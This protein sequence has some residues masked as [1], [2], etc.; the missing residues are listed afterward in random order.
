VVE[1]FA[2]TPVFAFYFLRARP[3]LA[4]AVIDVVPPRLKGGQT[5][6]M[7][8][9]TMCS[10]QGMIRGDDEHGPADPEQV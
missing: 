9:V 5:N 8:C 6:S 3:F 10:V 4:H 1:T 2:A 7:H